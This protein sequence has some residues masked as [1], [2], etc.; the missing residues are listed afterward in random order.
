VPEGIPANGG[1]MVA[2]YIVTA[3]ILV[4]YTIILYTRSRRL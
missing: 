4:A 3:L 1:Y 2:A